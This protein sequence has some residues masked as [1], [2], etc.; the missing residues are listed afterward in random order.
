[1]T[2]RDSSQQEMIAIFQKD[3]PDRELPLGYGWLGECDG[4]YAVEVNGNVAGAIAFNSTRCNDDGNGETQSTLE[5]LYVAKAYRGG[6]RSIGQR[7]CEF[8]IRQLVARDR[9]PIFCAVTSKAAHIVI[10][11]LP[12]E[13]RPYLRCEYSYLED[14]DLWAEHGF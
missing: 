9:T 2:L 14:G 5:L 11:R 6:G 1:M 4:I 7:L 12:A 3:N 10:D 8:G 13:L